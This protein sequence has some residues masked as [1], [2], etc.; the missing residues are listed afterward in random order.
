M[1]LQPASF[2]SVKYLV[3]K[4]FFSDV[5]NYRKRLLLFNKR[6]FPLPH[7]ALKIGYIFMTTPDKDATE[8]ISH[9]PA[10]AHNTIRPSGKSSSY[11][12]DSIYSPHSIGS[13]YFFLLLHSLQQ[14]TIFP[15]VLFPPRI[16]GT[17]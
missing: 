14:G 17:I 11:L 9:M 7:A 16:I 2:F 5:Y 6:A 12:N 13:I 10:V 4:G 3:Q 15:F 8:L 1:P